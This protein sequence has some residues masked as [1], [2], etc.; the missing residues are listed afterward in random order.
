MVTQRPRTIQ[1]STIPR[2]HPTPSERTPSHHTTP[3]HTT[4]HH[5]TPHHT[6]PHH[7][8]PHHTTPHHTTPHH[9]TPH[10]TTPH[11]TTPHHTTPDHT[12]LHSSAHK[13]TFFGQEGQVS[14][15]KRNVS[16]QSAGWDKRACVHCP[17]AKTQ[18]K[19]YLLQLLKS[20]L[21]LRK[22]FGEGVV[23]ARAL[24]VPLLSPGN[25]AVETFDGLRKG[26][27]EPLL[28]LEERRG[29]G[30]QFRQI[31]NHCRDEHWHQNE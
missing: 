4:P 16:C 3:H 12:T 21:E 31:N 10:H 5:T 2:I 22:L 18:C 15:R 19:T 14:V 26:R 24:A 7:T 25:V 30:G 17:S 23:L 20:V 11:H 9:T 27:V 29:G 28:A 1:R 6:T 8:T 13:H